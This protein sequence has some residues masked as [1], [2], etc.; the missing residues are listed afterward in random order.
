VIIIAAAVSG[1]VI[2]V[3]LRHT[4]ENMAAY[5]VRIHATRTI[6]AALLRE[7]DNL[8]VRYEDLVRVT[9]RP[10]GTVSSIQ[11]DMLAINRLKAQM[12]NSVI[13][14]LDDGAYPHTIRVPLGTLLGNEFLSGRGPM[15]GI[16]ILPVGYIETEIHN[17]FLSAGI[18][19]TL[20]QI[21]ITVNVRMTALIP[22]YSITT[23][24][25]TA[26]GIAETIIVGDIPEAFTQVGGDGEAS[27]LVN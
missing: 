10:D 8:G 23:D 22:G 4:V 19:Q 6:N 16:Q 27:V 5:Q 12:T 14:E 1:V 9:Q 24:T 21:V 20:H 25:V 2:A 17:Q 26:L 11:S 15:V 18:N 3:E 7:L 13:D